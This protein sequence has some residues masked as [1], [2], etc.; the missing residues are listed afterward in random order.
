MEMKT[1]PSNKSKQQNQ[2]QVLEK[3]QAAKTLSLLNDASRSKRFK[4]VMSNVEAR[5]AREVKTRF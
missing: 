2:Q 1:M 3:N 5:L 4:P